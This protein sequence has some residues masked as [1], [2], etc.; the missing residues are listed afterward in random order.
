MNAVAWLFT[1]LNAST[2]YAS[3]SRP[4]VVPQIV[5]VAQRSQFRPKKV[6]RIVHRIAAKID[7]LTQSTPRQAG[8]L[9]SSNRN[10]TAGQHKGH[11]PS[12]PPP[13]WLS[14]CCPT[15]CRPVAATWSF[16]PPSWSS[17]LTS[18]PASQPLP[19][20]TTARTSSMI[21]LLPRD[22]DVGESS[23][24]LSTGSTGTAQLCR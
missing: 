4:R 23:M 20:S 11:T 7:E 3:T 12:D 8:A 14:Y 13:C 18:T 9:K 1:L 16:A 10:H 6:P 2:C 15:I 22:S 21:F 19:S 24:L 5:R 17:P